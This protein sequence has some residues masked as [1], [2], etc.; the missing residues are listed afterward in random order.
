MIVVFRNINVFKI[1]C[2]SGRKNPFKTRC[3]GD[4]RP[5][6]AGKEKICESCCEHLLFIWVSKLLVILT[7]FCVWSRCSSNSENLAGGVS[8]TR[9][10]RQLSNRSAF[11]RS[12]KRLINCSMTVLTFWII[13]CIHCLFRTL[14]GFFCTFP[15]K[16]KKFNRI[17]KYESS[18]K[19]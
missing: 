7:S 14:K 18:Q 12:V 1:R 10:R 13:Y 2:W 16:C 19:H 4:N 8:N 11:T 3:K 5:Q 15:T 17:Q 9:H 6:F